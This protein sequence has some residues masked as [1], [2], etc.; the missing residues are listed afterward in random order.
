LLLSRRGA[1]LWPRPFLSRLA[2]VPRTRGRHS[3]RSPVILRRDGVS[4]RRGGPCGVQWA[5]CNGQSGH[6]WPV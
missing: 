2:G 3:R 5:A 6:A 4:C 1:A